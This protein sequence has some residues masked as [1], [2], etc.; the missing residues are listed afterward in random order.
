MEGGDNSNILILQS[1]VQG[2]V[3][4]ENNQQNSKKIK[5]SCDN[6][7]LGNSNNKNHRCIAGIK[8]HCGKGMF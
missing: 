8:T 7:L 1:T 4:Y 6:D 3:C 5:G 2:D